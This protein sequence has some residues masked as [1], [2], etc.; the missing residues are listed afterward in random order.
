[1]R[2]SA[3]PGRV[4]SQRLALAREYGEKTPEGD[5]GIP[6]RLTQT[7]LAA[8]VGAF[9]AGVNQALGYYRKRNLVSVGKDGR[10][11]VHDEG[12]L[13]RRTR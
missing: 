8:L 1:M 7:D 10:I 4:A 3:R 2:R 6:M 11:T 13:A 5:T 12:A 9:R